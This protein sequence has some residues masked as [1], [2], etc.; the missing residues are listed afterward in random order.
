M[1]KVIYYRT[2]GVCSKAIEIKLDG[3]IIKDVRFT[4]GCNGN[5]KGI[6]LLVKNMEANEVI[7]RLEN[8]CCGGKFTSCP[9]QLAKALRQSL[10]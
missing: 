5:L 6:A 1:E 4:G 10:Q 2:Q 3:K 8:V 9:A 7:E